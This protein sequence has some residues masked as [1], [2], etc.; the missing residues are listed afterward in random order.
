MQ[1]LSMYASILLIEATL[2]HQHIQTYTVCR[3]YDRFDEHIPKSTILYNPSETR[4]KRG[5]RIRGMRRKEM[6][7]NNIICN[8]FTCGFLTIFG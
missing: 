3:Q 5:D 4:Q 1:I 2:H 8:H 7:S 6:P